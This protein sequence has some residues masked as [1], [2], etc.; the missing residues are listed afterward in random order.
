MKHIVVRK[1]ILLLL[2]TLLGCETV[3]GALRDTANTARNVRD[4]FSAGKTVHDVIK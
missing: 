3:K 1:I 2:C 4:I